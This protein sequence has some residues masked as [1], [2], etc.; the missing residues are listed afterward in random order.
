MVLTPGDIPLGTGPPTREELLIYYPAKFTWKQLKTF[1]NSGDLRLLQRDKKLHLR[2]SEYMK[3]I[4]AQYGS[5]VNYLLTKRLRWGEP[6]RQSRLCSLLDEDHSVLDGLD[7]DCNETSTELPPISADA[8][9][10]FTADTPPELISIIM[11]D[12]PYSVPPEVEHILIWTRLPL[13]RPSIPPSIA[14]HLLEYGLWGFTGNTEPPPSPS[15][16]P[17]CLPALAD[18]NF[19]PDN[20]VHPPPRTEK[21]EALL[22]ETIDEISEFV[23]RKWKEAEWETAWF[24]NPSR[25]QSVPGLAHIHVLAKHKPSEEI[26]SSDKISRKYI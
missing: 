14:S 24:V 15:T 12:W 4:Q 1:V 5:T 3:G 6:D 22:R 21:E 9:H 11:N 2:F 7:S 10:H 17:E 18:W 23:R 16:L 19:T 13:L 20:I 8:P 25:W 26:N